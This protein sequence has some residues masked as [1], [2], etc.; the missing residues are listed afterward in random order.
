[1]GGC[2]TKEKK[3][4]EKAE[5]PSAADKVDYASMTSKQLKTLLAE[6]GIDSS[7]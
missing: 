4:T 2:G 5:Q 6:R 1:M 3:T 7:R